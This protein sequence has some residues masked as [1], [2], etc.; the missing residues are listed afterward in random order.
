MN[1]KQRGA[2]AE[3][4]VS[5]FLEEQGYR[6]I[7]RNYRCG[8]REVDI[9]AA[10]DGLLVIVEVKRVDPQLSGVL[11]PV[12]PR[13]EERLRQAAEELLM[14]HPEFSEV[15]FDVALAQ[16]LPDGSWHIRHLCDAF[17]TLH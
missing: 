15:R 3:R 16:V 6:I 12:H 13:Q 11:P 1:K 5:F 7:H 14:Q 9:V 8:Q 17:G 2:E 10:L 4:A